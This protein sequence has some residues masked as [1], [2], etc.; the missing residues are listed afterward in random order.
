MELKTIAEFVESGE[1]L[2][3]LRRLGVDEAQGY[4]LGR[5][6][7]LSRVLLGVEGKT[8]RVAEG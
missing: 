5:P 3:S 8:G 1:I 6:V 4:H 7:P 2:D